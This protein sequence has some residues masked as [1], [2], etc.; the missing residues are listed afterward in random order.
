M[1]TDVKEFKEFL[2]I[3]CLVSAAMASLSFVG[4]SIFVSIYSPTGTGAWKNVAY[5]GILAVFG[6]AWTSI[7]ALYRLDPKV[8]GLETE[9]GIEITRRWIWALLISSWG[10]FFLLIIGLLITFV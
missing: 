10:A 1:R 7:A 4:V 2:K 6:F 9:K 5:V 8:R 3:L